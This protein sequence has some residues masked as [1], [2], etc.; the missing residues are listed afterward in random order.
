MFQCAWCKKE[1]ISPYAWSDFKEPI[2]SECEYKYRI[3]TEQKMFA[4]KVSDLTK[5]QRRE[6]SEYINNLS[7]F[8]AT[9]RSIGKEKLTGKIKIISSATGW[10]F[11]ALFFVPIVL[12]EPF[13]NFLNVLGWIGSLY[14]FIYPA[15]A[16][17]VFN[18]INWWLKAYQ[19]KKKANKLGFVV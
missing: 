4:G 5:E 15:L 17:I 3:A 10:A 6:I 18:Q 16:F 12:F 13:L 9:Y 11:I 7:R 19:L 14:F 8:V 1:D 2:C